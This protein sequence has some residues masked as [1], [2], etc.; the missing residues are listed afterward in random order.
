MVRPIFRPVSRSAQTV[1][2]PAQRCAAAKFRTLG[3]AALLLNVLINSAGAAGGDDAAGMAQLLPQHCHHAGRYDQHIVADGFDDALRSSGAF[4]F[5]CDRGL[6]WATTAPVMEVWLYPLKGR[7]SQRLSSGDY[8][9]V[10]SRIHQE[11]GRLLNHLIGGDVAYLAKYFA[12]APIANGYQLQPKKQRMSQFIESIQLLLNDGKKVIVLEQAQQTMTITIVDD[13]HYE[14]LNH[15]TC[16][17]HLP[18]FPG[19]C[20]QLLD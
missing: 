1:A 17:Q 10:Q 18:T 3:G 7:P 12:L 8:V 14:N 9:A 2:A 20:T 19:A 5:S 11:L 16:V 4:V 6:I 15:R 13:Q